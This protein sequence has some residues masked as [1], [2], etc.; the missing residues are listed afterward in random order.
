MITLIIGYRN[1]D[2][3][4]VKKSLDSLAFQNKN[5]FEL[6]FIDYG[7]DL[8]IAST[9]KD[10]VYSY[11]FAKY[12]YVDTRGMFWNRAHALNIGVSYAK[13]EILVF[14]DVDL[15][16]EQHFLEKISKLSY[17]EFYYTFSCFY[18]PENFDY[19]SDIFK[20]GIHYE[21]N[22]VGL[23][24]LNKS[25]FLNSGGFDEYY[26]I[27]GVEDDD[28]Y[29]KLTIEGFKR[30]ELGFPEFTIYHQFHQIESP[31]KPDLWY[32]TMINHFYDKQL[33]LKSIS[34]FNFLSDRPARNVFE[35][36]NYKK[37]IKLI[38]NKNRTILMYNKFI[39]DFYELRS[40]QI[41]WF[42]YEIK[43]D[44]YLSPKIKSFIYSVFKSI[45]LISSS[46]KAYYSKTIHEPTFLEVNSFIAY[47]IGTHRRMI[48]DYYLNMTAKNISLVII[49]K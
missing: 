13:S 20:N 12:I 26:M 14:L 35:D 7:S 25:T 23:C 45:F 31:K 49:K 42:E 34:H 22:Y 36:G 17:N 6:I 32:L 48:S 18:L 28:L 43:N 29:K 38:L 46:N 11:P 40:N 16:L 15:I 47:F 44:N 4:R 27:W 33:D 9:I 2:L 37:N 21:Q 41:S 3:I 19:A 1:R 5:D 24:A 10:L 30:V 8:N 39:S